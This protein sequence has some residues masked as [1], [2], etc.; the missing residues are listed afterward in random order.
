MT[1]IIYSKTDESGLDTIA[2]LWEKLNEYHKERSRHFKH[3]FDLM[4]F[5]TRKQYSL[6]N[7]RGG[8]LR[9]DL[10]RDANSGELVG[11]CISTISVKKQGEIESIYVEPDY[12]RSGIGDIL[13]Q[14]ALSWMDDKSVNRKTLGVGAGNEEVFTFYSRY[15]F[16]PRV[17]ILEQVENSDNN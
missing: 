14:R 13:M 17:H 11:Y 16:H 15:N 9:V 12:R 5:E 10:A 6:E 4:T 8:A 3:Q 2:P 1:D 7:S